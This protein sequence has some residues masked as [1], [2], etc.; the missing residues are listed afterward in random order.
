MER[1]KRMKHMR[2]FYLLLLLIGNSYSFAAFADTSVAGQKVYQQ[3]CAGCHATGTAN[4]PRRDDLP[5][6]KKRMSEVT[7]RSAM[8]HAVITGKG[9]MPPKGGC[10]TCT[11]DMINTAVLYMVGAAGIPPLPPATPSN[12][13]PLDKIKL[14][15]GFSISLFANDLP[16]ARFMARGD[17]GTL[18]VGSRGKGNVYALVPDPSGKQAPRKITLL[19]GLNEPNGVAFYKG[20]L[21]VAEIG[22]ILKYDRIEDKLN[23][24]PKPIIIKDDLPLMSW[25]GYRV[26]GVG[27]DERLYITIGMPCNTCNYRTDNPWLGTISSMKLDGSDM[28]KFAIGVRNSVGITWHP[29]TKA[30]WF[31]DNGQDL[32]GD[33]IPPDEINS[34]PKPGMDFGFPYAFGNN[35]VAPDYTKEKIETAAFTPPA[36]RLPA[37]V[38]PLDLKFYTGTQFPKAYQKQLFV[39]L[40]GSWN[41]TAKDGYEVVMLT[42]ENNKVTGMKP[43]AT[44]WLQG[45]QAWGRPVGLL[46]QPDG[47]LLVSDDLNGLIYQI[48]YQSSL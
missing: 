18:F 27:P 43:F 5:F 40:H 39:A 25:H 32:L 46:V 45:Q 8:T 24:V 29:D 47:S 38:A 34:A 21:Y 41:R 12:A 16:G 2:L 20:A 4:A 19:S 13:L 48:T 17:K 30:L 28:E 9:A 36:W 1:M 10:A 22:R 6:W 15:D 33:D 26:I 14:P 42:L 7:G 23:K 37:H 44:G 35:T 31:S 3:Y 11:E